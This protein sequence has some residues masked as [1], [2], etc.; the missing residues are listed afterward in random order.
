MLSAKNGGARRGLRTTVGS[1]QSPSADRK[2]GARSRT[3]VLALKATVLSRE[4]R[5][6]RVLDG[7]GSGEHRCSGIGRP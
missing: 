7:S 3:P 1:D 6:D 4:L 2:V 5:D